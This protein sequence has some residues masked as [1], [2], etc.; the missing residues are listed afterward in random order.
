ML[1]VHILPAAWGLPSVSPFCLKLLTWLR[2]AGIEH[3]PVNANLQKAPRGKVPWVELDGEIIPDTELI[4]GR[5]G[6][7]FD[8]QLD[9]R[10]DPEQHARGHVLRRMIEE[11]TYFALVW[12]RWIDD[13]HFEEYLR[14]LLKG[15]LPPVLNLALPNVIRNGVRKQL[16]QQGI[17]RNDRATIM[18]KAL[19]D[20]D[21]IE[22][23]LGVDS[24][25]L[26]K[27]P[28]SYDAAA[29]GVLGSIAFGPCSPELKSRVE[30]SRLG[31]Y[32]Q[33]IR[34]RSWAGE[35]QPTMQAPGT[36]S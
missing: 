30:G 24:F 3:E 33:R 6:A 19:A 8:V 36:R 14:P 31:L 13:A 22:Q 27:H 23:L 2:L 12:D 16:H 18:A 34:D 35:E 32:C 20:L 28:S 9:A 15:M 17:G 29:Y 11:H 21:A 10:F 25:L 7:H 1:T 26:G 5:L 4:I